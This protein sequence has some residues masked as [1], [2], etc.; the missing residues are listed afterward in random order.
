MNH[1]GSINAGTRAAYTVTR[2]DAYNNLVTAGSDTAY[3]YSSSTGAYAFY[4]AASGGS[5]ITSVAISGSSSA[6]FWYYDD[7]VGTWIITASDNASAPDGTTGIDD[8]TDSLTVNTAPIVATR[9]VILNPTDSTAG[10]AVTVTVQAQ[11]D[12]GSVDTT[13]QND[14]TLVTSGSA[15]GGGLVDIING[16]GTININDLVAQTVNLTLSDTQGTGLNVSSSQD[17]IF[18]PGSVSQFILNNPGDMTAGTRLGYTLTRADQYGNAVTVGSDVAYLYSSSTSTAKKFYNASS[19]GSVVTSVSI[20]AGLSSANF[21]YY[22]ESAGTYTITGSDNAS[23][24]DGAIGIIDATDS[25]QVSAS[26]VSQFTLNDPGNTT[27]GTRL[28]YTVVRRD[29]FGNPVTSGV[30]TIYLYSSSAGANKFFYNVSSGGSPITSISINNGFSS[31][32]FW[33]YDELAGTYTVTA[34]DNASAPDGAAGI[35]DASDSATVSADVISQ[36]VLNNPGD[37]VAGNR[38]GYTVSRKDQFGNLVGSGINTVYLYSSSIG[39]NKKFYDAASGGNIITSINIIGGQTSVNVWYYDELSGGFTVTASDNASAPDGPTGITDATDSVTVSPN[40]TAQFLL[41]NPGNMTAGTRLGYTVSRKDAFGNNVTSGTDTVY[42]YSSSTGVN[43]KFYDAASGG[44]IITSINIIGGGSTA[45]FWYYDD[46]LGTWTITA[47]DNSSAPDGTTGID[48]A[49]DSVTV[50]AAPIV[51]TKFVILNPTDGTVGTPIAVTVEAQNNSG[52]IDTSYQ[53]DVTLV[54]SGSATGGGLVNIINGVG[55]ININD[56]VAETVN[57]SLSDTQGTGLNVSSTQ[58]VIFAPGP[59][60]QFIIDNPGNITAGDRLGYTV[61]RKD[62]YGNLV[63]AGSTSVYLYSNS[64]GPNAK[65][66]N[67]SSGGSVVTSVSINAGSSSANFWYYDESAGG[68]SVTV[69]DNASAPDGAA[70]IADAIDAVTVSPGSVTQFTLNNPGNMT[71]GTR[72]G[73]TVSRKDAFGNNV[74]SGATAVYFYSS[75]TGVNKKFYDAAS[76]GNIIT[77][78]NIGAGSSSANFWYYDELA[79]LWTVTTSDNATAPDGASGIADAG[80]AVTVAAGSVYRFTLDDPGNMTAGTRLQYTV[81][82]KDQFDNSVTSGSTTVYLYS[83]STGGSKAFYNAAIGGSQILSVNIT[84]TLSSVN[85]WYYDTALG[86][87]LISA[88]DNPGAPDGATGVL[89][90]SDMTTVLAAPI[91]ATKFVIMEP[92]DTTVGQIV[93]VT[94]KA[95]DNDGNTDTTYQNDVT[96][97]TSGSATGGGLI[98][99]VNGVGTVDISDTVA[100]TVNLSLSDTQGTGLD[101]SSTKDVIFSEVVLPPTPVPMVTPGTSIGAKI[102]AAKFQI[103]IVFS[104][105][106][107]PGGKVTVMTQGLPENFPLRQSADLPPDGGFYVEYIGVPPFTGVSSYALLIEDKDGRATQ[108]K[109]YAPNIDQSL[110][111]LNIFAPPTVGLSQSVVAKG[112]TLEISGYGTP[113]SYIRSELDGAAFGGDVYVDGSGAYKITVDT[114][115]LSYGDH[116]FRAIQIDTSGIVSDFSVLKHFTVSL[117]SGL[118][119]DLNKD[120]KIDITDFSIFLVRWASKVMD[121]K[122]TVDFDGDGKLAISDFSIFLMAIKAK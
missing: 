7:A 82:R 36:F 68:W 26:A 60:T 15:T 49:T 54:T 65:F 1:P 122:K 110:V 34:S 109:L 95:E 64:T 46:A 11:N 93:T 16:V 89:D 21:W 116:K 70:G 33:Y 23:A 56:T 59:V 83:S 29:Q 79:G 78:L 38:L 58:D 76:G 112:R 28:G 69:S 32:N 85:F 31:V 51:A 47:S 97:V 118:Q 101:V 103:V 77:S 43:K 117:A 115:K 17:V 81:A 27:A 50:S 5:V 55:T 10:T 96:L 107:F 3:L 88:S 80:D 57:L 67:A 102:A 71:A 108:T 18:S 120:G 75:S 12:G 98:N 92:V 66:Y 13:Y 48:D 45:N 114:N 74:T 22:D 37:M 42:L 19:G 20:N 44:N 25:V 99:I 63:T 61:T 41:N 113:G 35:A 9:F 121:M 91:V 119:A 4:N 24:P 6:N 104:G 94:V 73:Y 53:N 87:W 52:S 8:A 86:S 106:A 14:V 2:K 62:Q 90:A 84:D 40:N 100:E 105:R 30:T 111:V 72:L 39:V